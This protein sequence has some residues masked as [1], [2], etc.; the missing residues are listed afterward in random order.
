[1]ADF[2]AQVTQLLHKAASG[3]RKAV[4]ELFPLVYEDLRQRAGR[5][6]G[7]KGPGRSPTLQPTALVHEAYIK[8]VGGAGMEYQSRQ[9]FYNT[10]A[11]AMRRILVDYARER[12]AEKRGG[13]RQRVDFEGVDVPIGDAVDWIALDEAMKKLEAADPRRHEVVMLHHFAGLQLKE[14]A[15]VMQVTEKTVQRDWKAAKLFLLTELDEQTE[16]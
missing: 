14:I 2:Q 13:G 11:R 3:D 4:N 7:R 5:Y 12:G 6:A 9:H 8:L 1:M 16:S 15:D 10:A